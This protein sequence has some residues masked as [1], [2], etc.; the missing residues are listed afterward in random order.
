METIVKLENISKS[1]QGVEVLKDLN[2]TI[3]KGEFVAIIGSSGCGKSTLLN[4]IGLL[5]KQDQGDM[6]LFGEKNVRPFSHKAEMILRDRIG[7][8]FQNYALIENQTVGY[9]LEIVFDHKV[10]KEEKK[11]KIQEALEKVGLKGIENKKVFKCSGGEQQRIALARLLI[12]PCDLVLA[13]EPTGNLDIE[14]REKV[15]QILKDLNQLGKTIILVTH[16]LDVAK[17]CQKVF[18]MSNHQIKY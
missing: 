17:E 1:F 3:Q 13:D 15:L 8:L 2:L 16:D 5:D 7:Y 14:N 10:K 6:T 4:I 12:K 9:N 11:Q 18:K